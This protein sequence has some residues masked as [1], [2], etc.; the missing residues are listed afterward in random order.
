MRPR[1]ASISSIGAVCVIWFASRCLRS[2][3]KTEPGCSQLI[4]LLTII[5]SANVRSAVGITPMKRYRVI[6]SRHWRSD[7][8]RFF[9]VAYIALTS[10]WDSFARASVKE[11]TLF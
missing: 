3:E 6:K 7:A 1:R 5:E 8:S 4:T 9:T 11:A 10:L 2:V